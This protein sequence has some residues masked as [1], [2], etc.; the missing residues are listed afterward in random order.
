MIRNTK[1]RRKIQIND[2]QLIK[3]Q[4]H[5]SIMLQSLI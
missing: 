4:K 1:E 5:D 2:Y 3:M